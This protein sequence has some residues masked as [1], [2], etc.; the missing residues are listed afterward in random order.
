MGIKSTQRGGANAGRG[1]NPHHN[2]K[3][4]LLNE[5]ASIDAIS[6]DYANGKDKWE[7]HNWEECT[8]PSCR[9]AA[10]Q[11][12]EVDAMNNWGNSTG[13]FDGETSTLYGRL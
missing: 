7:S 5:H 9:Q 10:Q 2:K 3:D 11:A 12:S 4:A 6:G 1:D 13:K 8:H